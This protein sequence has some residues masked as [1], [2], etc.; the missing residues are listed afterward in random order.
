MPDCIEQLN[1]ML[2]REAWSRELDGKPTIVDE[3]RQSLPYFIDQCAELLI[4]E[5]D[6]RLL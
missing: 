4:P 6:G 2:L 5:T 3:V 1:E